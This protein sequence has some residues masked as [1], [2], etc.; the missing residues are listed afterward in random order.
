VKKR[1]GVMLTIFIGIITTFIVCVIIS[2]KNTEQT[3]ATSAY[4]FRILRNE[5][6]FTEGGNCSAVVTE[7]GNLYIWG[8]NS[9][10]QIGDGTTENKNIP[11]KVSEQVKSVSLGGHHSAAITESKDLYVW[12]ANWNGQIGNGSTEN[13]N[14]PIKI[15]EHVKSVDLGGYHSA[16]VTESG[17]LYV[18]GYNLDGQI[19][20]GTAENKNT[21]VKIMEHVKNV[22]LGGYHSAAITESGDLYIWG[23]NEYGQVGDGTV[24]SKNTPVKIMEHVKSVS[25]GCDHSAAITE[26]GDLYIW[27]NNEYG[28]IGNGTSENKNSPIKIMEHVKDVSLGYDHSAAVTESGDLYVWGYNRY[29]Q[30]G[31]GTTEDKAIPIKIME[32][33][34]S[35]DLGYDHSAVLTKTEELYVWGCNTYGQIGDGTTE[36]KGVPIKIIDNIHEELPGDDTESITTITKISGAINHYYGVNSYKNTPEG[37]IYEDSVAFINAMDSYLTELKKA[38]QKDIQVINK[39]SKS[40]AQRLK[41]ADMASDYKIINMEAKIP[42]AALD[43]VYETLAQ[44]L[45]MY[46]EKGVSLGKIDMSASTIEISTSI[47]NKIRNNLDSIDFTRTV[48]RY[49]VKFKILKFMGAAYTGSVNVQGNGKFYTGIIV[50]T[51]QETAKVLNTYLNDISKWAEDAL[52]QSLKAVFTELT[53][54]T[55]IADYTKKEIK[56]LL[57]DNVKLLQNKGYGNLLTYW[58]KMRD[59]YDICQKIVS[60]KD[61]SSLTKALKDVKSIYKKIEELNY[62]DEDVSNK[63]V[64][65]AMSKLNIMKN[66]LEYSLYCYIYNIDNTEK[67]DKDNWWNN[68]WSS[69]KSFFVQCPV[70]FTLYDS[71]GNELGKVS[72][73]EVI[74]TSDIYISVDDDV[75]TIIVPADMD[76]QIKFTGA[77]T[78]YMTYVIEQTVDK[79]ITGRVNYYNIPLSDGLTYI[80]SIPKENLAE[81]SEIQLIS[82]NG[83]YTPDEYISA[84][85]KEAYVTVN[86]DVDGGGTVNGIGSYAKGSPVA[87]AAYSENESY[88]FIGWYVNNNLVETGSIYRFAAVSDVTVQA[89]FEEYREADKTYHAVMSKAYEELADIIVYRYS[90][91][92]KEII[93]SMAGL[94]EIES[95]DVFLKEYD[96]EGNL[97]QNTETKTIYDGVYR[98]TIPALELDD[99]SKIEIYNDKNQLIG[100]VKSG[101]SE[102]GKVMYGD[103]NKDGE[104]TTKDAVLIKKYLAEYIGLNIDLT[105]AD[106]NID[107]DVD[108]KDAVRLLRYLA[109]YEVVL[110]E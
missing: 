93:I 108:S 87:L 48:G 85:D 69:F 19:G 55:G 9:S 35:V 2:L 34:Q 74:Y 21:P 24:E 53:S 39:T 41:E 79:E 65:Q 90:S 25:L 52:Y 43:S 31:N 33:I 62:S 63:I 12:G 66:N 15:M 40:S 14:S 32:N 97:I 11:V 96:R 10:G 101:D 8:D 46:V 67:E 27:G 110:G 3:F 70:N 106:V 16:A 36:N 88:K 71:A 109:E 38:T 17:D 83:S 7:S 51:P 107:G 6:L 99:F 95:L 73:E 92:L 5:V 72:D 91:N 89:V 105:A 64:K 45:D 81:D 13:K 86:C 103:A 28:Q 102:E 4:S 59:G 56:A 42:D 60:A 68:I 76:V 54:I 78:G 44:Y 20:D 50:S 23:N 77:D 104:I 30:I 75:K 80:Q 37:D 22:S 47:V 1:K 82:D 18:W 98:F 57:K 58:T 49:T 94:D 61:A 100:T 29:G 26:S 84:D